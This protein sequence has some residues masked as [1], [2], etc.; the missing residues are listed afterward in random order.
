MFTTVTGFS[1]LSYQ[2]IIIPMVY[3][4]SVLGR[5]IDYYGC[6]YSIFEN[7]T[8]FNEDQ[9]PIPCVGFSS[10]PACLWELPEYFQI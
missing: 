3:K 9:D 7:K 10:S 1:G 5:Q 2:V 4:S 8:S 6:D